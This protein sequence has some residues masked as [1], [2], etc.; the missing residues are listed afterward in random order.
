VRYALIE[1]YSRRSDQVARARTEGNKTVLFRAEIPAVGR[2][3][4]LRITTADAFTL[5][6]ETVEEMTHA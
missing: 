6:G 2:I 3:V 4:P 5:H 1:G